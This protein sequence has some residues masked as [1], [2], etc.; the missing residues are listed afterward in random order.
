[1]SCEKEISKNSPLP[2]QPNAERI[3]PE[4]MESAMNNFIRE[5]QEGTPQFQSYEAQDALLVIEAA[6]NFHT[7]TPNNS[8]DDVYVDNSAFTLT[9]YYNEERQEYD[10]I[11]DLINVV[12]PEVLEMANSAR[13]RSPFS[14]NQNAFNSVVDLEFSNIE[15]LQSPPDNG[16]SVVVEVAISTVVANGPNGPN[17]PWPCTYGANDY[18]NGYYQST[19]PGGCGS[20]TNTTSTCFKEMYKKLSASC[21]GFCDG[22]YFT[23]ITFNSQLYT[24]YPGNTW[25]CTPYNTYLH[26]APYGTGQVCF[27][28]TEMNCFTE[29]A[30]AAAAYHAP[31][32]PL[33]GSK[34]C[35]LSYQF[36][37][38]L[39]LCNCDQF[40]YPTFKYGI[41]RTFN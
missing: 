18:W 30:R 14:S 9:C 20:N 32:D 13:S 10:V 23:N 33:T 38:Y 7:A 35:V 27:T 24:V 37:E 1:M 39:P 36:Y 6:L 15:L 4:E 31:V 34:Y 16:E 22:G 11:G 19:S 17:F 12:W 40:H 8:Y 29:G 25:H 26:K 28:P 41:A 2:K 21:N 3:N 5:S